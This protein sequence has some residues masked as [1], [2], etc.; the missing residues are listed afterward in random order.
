MGASL[1]V[2]H[3]TLAELPGEKAEMTALLAHWDP[4]TYELRIY[5]CGHVA[6]RILRDGGE[7]ETLRFDESHGLGGRRT[8]KPSEY[9][10]R[11]L[12][13]D[14][15]LMVSDGVVSQR[16][17]GVGLA[18]EVLIAAS[19]GSQQSSASDTVREIHRAVLAA[20][21]AGGLEDDATVLCLA[22]G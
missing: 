10:S 15:L 6:P 21:P 17:G 3:Q 20:S 12:V 5:N 18:P 2:M 9:R 16:D 7:T 8:P 1:L 14:R 4:T 19:L 22:T 13:G 11:L